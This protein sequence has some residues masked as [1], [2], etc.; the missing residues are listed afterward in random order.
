MFGLR[1][2]DIWHCRRKQTPVSRVSFLTREECRKSRICLEAK[3]N[4]AFRFH[5]VHVYI[6]PFSARIAALIVQVASLHLIRNSYF[7]SIISPLLLVFFIENKQK[8]VE[9]SDHTAVPV[10]VETR[11]ILRHRRP[12]LRL[13]MRSL[14]N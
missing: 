14:L 12:M 11:K 5:R 6:K 2:S 4:I 8:T 10:Q 3:T 13:L 1:L 9:T 7:L